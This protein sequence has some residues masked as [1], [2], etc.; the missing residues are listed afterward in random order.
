MEP[1]LFIGSGELLMEFPIPV[2]DLID[3]L[4]IIFGK[5]HGHIE[6]GG[7]RDD[8][9]HRCHLADHD[10]DVV[11]FQL[12]EQVFV[13]AQFRIGVIIDFQF[14]A[15]DLVHILGHQFSE[16]LAGG[17]L[18][19]R[20]GSDQFHGL[21]FGIFTAPGRFFFGFFSAAAGETH[22]HQTCQQ[23]TCRFFPRFFHDI[24]SF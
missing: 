11:G 3:G 1:G 7:F 13:P 12:S 21:Q 16:P 6:N 2:Q 24:A 8:G 10:L 5:G 23:D 19:S 4:A 14:A 9:G 15:S 20:V 22:E 17:I 18:S